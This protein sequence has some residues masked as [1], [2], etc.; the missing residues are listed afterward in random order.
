MANYYGGA[1]FFDCRVFLIKL[2]SAF[3]DF[4][5]NDFATLFSGIGFLS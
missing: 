2:H 4:I 3:I 1:R 5:G